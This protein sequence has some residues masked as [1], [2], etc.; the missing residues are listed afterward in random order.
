MNHSYITLPSKFVQSHFNGS[1]DYK[2]PPP[3]I[4]GTQEFQ[5][6]KI[7]VKLIIK[8]NRKRACENNMPRKK[9]SKKI[10]AR[11]NEKK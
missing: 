9:Q 7:K 8:W 10:K 1:Q 2:K 4:E 6:N 11:G 5:K 3:K